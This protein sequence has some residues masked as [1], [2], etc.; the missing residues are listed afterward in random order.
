MGCGPELAH[1]D[2]E[3]T[4]EEV[5]GR[6]GVGPAAVGR[7][8]LDRVARR[9]EAAFQFREADAND[10]VVHGLVL[11]FAEAKVEQGA[12]DVQ[13]RGYLRGSDG[14]GGVAFDPGERLLDELA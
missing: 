12:R 2:A 13:V 5:L 6:I 3:A 1:G 9:E 10:R 11:Q 14:R 7:D 4:L 8:L